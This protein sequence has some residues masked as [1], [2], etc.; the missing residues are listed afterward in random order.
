MVE[1]DAATHLRALATKELLAQLRQAPSSTL[2]K[3]VAYEGVRSAY[4]SEFGWPAELD[5]IEPGPARIPRWLNRL[6]W[7]VADLVQAGILEKSSGSD[8][9]SATEMGK[10]LIALA[11]PF[12]DTPQ[13]RELLAAVAAART[14]PA[15]NAAADAALGKFQA[16]FPADRLANMSLQDYAIGGGDQDNFC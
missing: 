5:E 16:R 6:H 9:L 13:T 8:D 11:S 7:A 15:C 10:G 3:K 2:P 4:T 14:D 12:T 1:N